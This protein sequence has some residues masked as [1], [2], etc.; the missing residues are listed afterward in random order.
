MTIR[1]KSD[2]WHAIESKLLR[3]YLVANYSP[4]RKR[5]NFERSSKLA[6]LLVSS[7]VVAFEMRRST[8]TFIFQTKCY[9]LYTQFMQSD[10]YNVQILDFDEVQFFSTSGENIKKLYNQLYNCSNCII[11]LNLFLSSQYNLVYCLGISTF[12]NAGEP[13]A[14]TLFYLIENAKVEKSAVSQT[15]WLCCVMKIYTPSL[16]QSRIQTKFSI[17]TW[18]NK[19]IKVTDSHKR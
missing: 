18:N 5:S 11:H 9:L 19:Q 17:R 15:F 13:H 8:W 1:P 16:P 3:E 7:S 6:Q 4:P 10:C 2:R 14:E 12:F